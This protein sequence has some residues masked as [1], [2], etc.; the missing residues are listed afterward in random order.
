M[1]ALS[2]KGQEATPWVPGMEGGRRRHLLPRRPIL[3]MAVAT[4]PFPSCHSLGGSA[5]AEADGGGFD[6]SSCGGK[7]RVPISLP[8]SLFRAQSWGHALIRK[9]STQEH[10]LAGHQ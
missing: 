9:E 1:Q 6:G 4:T 2:G 10:T 5:G 3:S 8:A 7:G